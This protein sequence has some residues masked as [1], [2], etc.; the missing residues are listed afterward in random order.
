MLKVGQKVV[1]ID[2]SPVRAAPGTALL[3]LA[4]G[5]V[6]TVRSLHTEPHIKGYGVLPSMK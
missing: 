2:G 5:A 4:E 3:R 6:Y 1:C